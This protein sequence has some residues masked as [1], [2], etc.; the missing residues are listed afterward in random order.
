MIDPFIKY[1]EDLT[2]IDVQSEVHRLWKGPEH[3]DQRNIEVR[4]GVGSDNISSQ[5]DQMKDV[6]GSSGDGKVVFFCTSVADR[7]KV[8]RKVE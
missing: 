2:T 6:L 7:D 1:L 8:Q 4:I 5:I 3:F